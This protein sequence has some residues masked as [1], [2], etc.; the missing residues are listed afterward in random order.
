MTSDESEVCGSLCGG[1][2]GA[3][4]GSRLLRHCFVAAPGAG[5]FISVIGSRLAEAPEGERLVYPQRDKRWRERSVAPRLRAEQA[6]RFAIRPEAD[7]D[8][9]APGALQPNDRQ[10]LCT[11]LG[12]W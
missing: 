11:G 12:F 10:P 5:C 6:R 3:G 1:L 7:N 4:A 9:G 2:T 8:A